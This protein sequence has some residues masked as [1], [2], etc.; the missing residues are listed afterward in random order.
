M[1]K[2]LVQEQFGKTAASY[3]TSAPHA[4]GAS[5]ER[6]VALTQPQKSWRG[7]DIATGGGHVA[8]T[9]APHVARMWAT[10]IT[11]EM[12]D[13]V[14]AEAQKRG[15]SNIRTA[16]AKAE[17]LPFEDA[18]FDLVTCR[19]AP[20]HFDS[21]PDFLSEVHR[22]LKAGGVCAVVDNVV[23]AGSVGDYVNA[24]ER[25]RD[26]S[27]LRAWTMEEWRAALT[28]AGLKL[29]HEEQIYKQMEFKSWAARHDATMQNF[30]RAMLTEMTPEVKAVME[31]AGRGDAL[32][33]RLCEGLFIAKKT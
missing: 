32:T 15:L 23:P 27:H 26:P 5:L 25:F 2:T 16:Y 4:K 13:M 10:D 31:P 18:S 17:A 8:Y 28:K 20:H 21:I 1:S 9:F 19:I 22:V 7:V 33:F 3:L 12:L 14:R 11:Q 6:L 24:F 29:E 30:L